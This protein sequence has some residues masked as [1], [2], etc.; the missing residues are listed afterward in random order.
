VFNEEVAIERNLAEILRH[1]ANPGD[2][3][4]LKRIICVDDGSSDRTREIL[5]RLAREN[6]LFMLISL[7][8]NFGKE[9]A[10]LAGLKL[11]E[12]DA[13][14]VMDSDLQH[15]PALIPDMVR[16]WQSGC[17]VVE[18]YKSHRGRESLSSK[19]FAEGFYAVFALLSRQDLR[20]HS[21]FKLLDRRVVEEY[22]RLPERGRFFRGLVNWMGFP[23]ARIPFQV[24]E[25]SGGDSTW[26]R[27][28]RLRFSIDAITSF[29]AAPLQL[30]GWIGAVTFLLTATLSLI[31]LY[32]K[33]TGRAVGGF[34]TVILLTLLVSSV[35]MVSIGIMGIYIGKIYEELKF[36]PSYYVR[37]IIGEPAHAEATWPVP[38]EQSSR[39]GHDVDTF[40]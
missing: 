4:I 23:V 34:T 21:D 35:L 18:G 39:A 7:T 38:Q 10:M 14:I 37:E 22:C 13:V 20:N 3:V 32:Q 25:R 26:S 33:F 28:R 19:L 1:A 27:I 24:A 29:S 2:D 36:R 8:R 5:S 31:A 11:A 15:P 12:G 16:I 6:S 17:M 40:R 9:A 30:I